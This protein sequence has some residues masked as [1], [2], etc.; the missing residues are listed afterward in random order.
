MTAAVAMIAANPMMAL[1]VASGVFSA[2]QSIRQGAAAEADY[3]IKAAQAKV[4]AE[5]EAVNA[6]IE[7][8]NVLRKLRQ[9]N[10]SAVARGFA[11][12]VSGFSGSAKLV[13]TVN[14]T[15]AGRDFTQ[16]Q[17]TAKERR[18][19][20][21]I[22]SQMFKEAG[23]AAK[24]SST[25]DALTGITTAAISTYALM[26]GGGTTPAPATKFKPYPSYMKT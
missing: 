9:T 24:D 10:S 11:G 26:P 15:Y 21:D 16:L 17:A 4:K 1:Q 14:E 12:G 6:E 19:F 13:Q 3:E 7:A 25:F 5:R 20:G 18:S 23:D 2:V 8:N 22:Q